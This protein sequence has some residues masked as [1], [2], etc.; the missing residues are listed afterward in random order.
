MTVTNYNLTATIE[1]NSNN[2]L[3]ETY[4]YTEKIYNE[5]DDSIVQT[6]ISEFSFT[7]GN[8]NFEVPY[9]PTTNPDA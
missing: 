6:I 2:G 9:S 5:K 8:L 3:V 1:S 7:Y 4:K